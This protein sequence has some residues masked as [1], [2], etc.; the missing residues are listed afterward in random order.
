MLERR[1]QQQQH[2]RN[3]EFQPVFVFVSV[4]GICASRSFQGEAVGREVQ[5]ST[6]TQRTHAQEVRKVRW[7]DVSFRN[8]I[9]LETGSRLYLIIF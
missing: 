7:M 1:K 8:A 5:T 3:I 4:V 6:L 2:Q 9:D